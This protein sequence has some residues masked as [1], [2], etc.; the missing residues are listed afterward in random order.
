MLRFYGLCLL[1]GLFGDAF[2][3]LELMVVASRALTARN[4]TV[5]LCIER[6]GIGGMLEYLSARESRETGVS[7]L[8]TQ[9][10]ASPKS[11]ARFLAVF[12]SR[13]L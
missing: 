2:P 10:S 4:V 12:G 13:K 5:K 8:C 7:M 11:I 3:W 9:R 1:L 6:C